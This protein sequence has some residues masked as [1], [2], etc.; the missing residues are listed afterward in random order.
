VNGWIPNLAKHAGSQPG[1][2]RAADGAAQVLE[3]AVEVGVRISLQASP[4]TRSP[5][6]PPAA[7][8]SASDNDTLPPS[9]E[10][11]GG[12]LVRF[13][14]RID[15][16]QREVPSVPVKNVRA[17]GDARYAA[18]VGDGHATSR[19]QPRKNGKLLW[20][21]KVDSPIRISSRASLPGTRY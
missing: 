16:P 2:R 15:H 9:S 3:A 21:T 12:V 5:R 13:E 14:N 19:H 7:S 4:P 8:S 20:K 17:T 1:E 6:S 11:G 18:F 10:T